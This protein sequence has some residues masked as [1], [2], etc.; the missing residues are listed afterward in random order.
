MNT[1][2][3]PLAKHLKFK[4]VGNDHQPGD[5]REYRVYYRGQYL[6][7]VGSDYVPSSIPDEPVRGFSYTSADRTCTGMGT[8]RAAAV[9]DSYEAS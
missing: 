9:I 1:S 5:D 8:T 3:A 2:P 4:L 7:D 6:G